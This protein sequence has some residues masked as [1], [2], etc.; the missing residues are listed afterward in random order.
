MATIPDI[1]DAVVTVLNDASLSQSYT[2]VRTY[3]PIYDLRDI[4]S[5]TITVVPKEQELILADRTQGQMDFR[6]DIGIQKKLGD[7]TSTG[8]NT[9]IDALMTLVEEIIDLIRDT[10]VFGVAKWLKTENSPIFAPE[11]LSE[12]RVFTSVLTLTL[13]A[14]IA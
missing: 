12:M 11:H 13:R 7:A 4:T 3:R 8:D 2:A 6:L 10:R 14:F 9:E 5:L 1:A